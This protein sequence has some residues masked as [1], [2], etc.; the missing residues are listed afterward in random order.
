MR[1]CL[2]TF[3][4]EMKIWKKSLDSMLWARGTELVV[5][6]K[7]DS[8]LSNL[9]KERENLDRTSDTQIHEKPAPM[10]KEIWQNITN[11]K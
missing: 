7:E 5:K 1:K 10:E 3:S 4:S 6:V 2:E 8:L 11:N 9:I